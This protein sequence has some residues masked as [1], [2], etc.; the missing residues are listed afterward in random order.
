MHNFKFLATFTAILT[1]ILFP[2]FLLFAQ[3]NKIVVSNGALQ[4]L[5]SFPIKVSVDTKK[6]SIDSKQF[7]S[8]KTTFYNKDGYNSELENVLHCK[9]SIDGLKLCNLTEPTASLSHLKKGA[10][11]SIMHEEIT[12]FLESIESQ[13]H[14]DPKNGKFEMTEDSGLIVI[15]ASRK[16]QSL[17]IDKSAQLISKF[18]ESGEYEN[19]TDLEIATIEPEIS[20]QNIRGLGISSQIGHGESNFRGSPRNRIHNIKVAT[21]RFDGHIL[22]PGEEFSFTEI[23]GPVNRSTRYKEELVIKENKTIPEFGGGVCQVSTTMFRVALNAGM[24]ITERHNHAYPVQYYSPQGT[25][26]TIYL[27]KPDFKFLNNTPGHI[28]IQASFE[29]SKLSFDFFGT[30]DNREVEISG[31]KVTQ[32]TPDGKMRT[33]LYQTVKDSSGAIVL[34]DTFKS[35]YDNPDKYHEPEFKTKP[36]DWSKRQWEKYA[37]QHGI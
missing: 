18:L 1:G 28:L 4:S 35:F 12:S 30:S 13:V 7:I 23:L 6:Y 37:A 3:E 14:K 32:R 8:W 20:S 21:N 25:D 11:L 15:E 19:T 2:C 29:G 9:E 5:L 27:P 24:R 26:A 10:I 16:G 22:K 36:D 34:E 17:D 33:I 31:P